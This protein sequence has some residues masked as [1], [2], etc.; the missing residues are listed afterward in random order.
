MN[1]KVIEK[2]AKMSPKEREIFINSYEANRDYNGKITDEEFKIYKYIT[3]YKTIRDRL[4]NARRIECASCNWKGLDA[5]C[6]S[7]N[8]YGED[9]CPA[10]GCSYFTVLN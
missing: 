3:K 4:K 9:D 7:E 2:I 6:T 5:D 1:D 10:C 8:K